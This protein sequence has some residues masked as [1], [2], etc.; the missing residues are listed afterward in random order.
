MF[1]LLATLI[2]WPTPSCNAVGT[3]LNGTR[4]PDELYLTSFKSFITLKIKVVIQLNYIYQRHKVRCCI[5]I[6]S[7]LAITS[8]AAGKDYFI[9]VFKLFSVLI[10]HLV[11]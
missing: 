4:K 9:I 7:Y 8:R 11:L 6:L 5:M 10:N 1:A 3:V 2:K